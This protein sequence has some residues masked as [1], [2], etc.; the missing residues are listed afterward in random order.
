MKELP[1][2]QEAERA[3]LGAMLLNA[4]AVGA[5]IE[6]IREDAEFVFHHTPHQHVYRAM[7]ALFV[8]DVP[9]D[10]VTLVNELMQAGAFAAAGGATYLAELSRAVPTSANVVHYA[11]AVMDV[12]SLRRIITTTA[13]LSSEAYSGDVSFVDM[14]TKAQKQL[15]DLA[16]L[17][18]G[19]VPIAACEAASAFTGEVEAMIDSG[20]R[21]FGL[22][23]GVERLDSV[24]HGMQRKNLI[25]LAARPG[26]GKSGLAEFIALHTAVKAKTPVIFFTMEMSCDEVIM[27]AMQSLGQVEKDRIWT[28]FQARPEVAKMHSVTTMLDGV[29]LMIVDKAGMT[30]LDIKATAKRFAAKHP[31][32]HGLVVIDYLQLLAPTD[33]KVP[34]QE[35]VAECSREAKQLANELDWTTLALSQLNRKGDESDNSRP[36]MSHLRESGAIEQDANVILLMHEEKGGTEDGCAVTVEVAKNRGGAKGALIGLWYNRR[37]QTFHETT[38]NAK[39]EEVAR[40]PYADDIERTY[41]ESDDMAF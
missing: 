12:A 1:H 40:L 18:A 26:V 22:A 21:M 23:T 17:R 32:Q 39:V 5:A 16:E 37:R 13:T 6:I 3:V 29:P 25:V 33:R 20:K 2:N 19:I 24:L 7:L 4:G 34:R 27:R 11:R 36:R 38:S 28:G 35:Q 41:D 30:I 10:A 31:G 9:I 8:A 14:L 15:S